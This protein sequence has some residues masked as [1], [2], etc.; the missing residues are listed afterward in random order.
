[1][2][3]ELLDEGRDADQHHGEQATEGEFGVL[4]AAYPGLAERRH[5]IG[6]R[7]D[8][9]QRGAAAG[10]GLEQQQDT[11]RLH[12]LGLLTEDVRVDRGAAAKQ[13][14]EDHGDDRADADDR[15]QDERPRAVRD[16]A[17]VDHG[18]HAEADPHGVGEQPGER[19][20]QRCHTGGDG[21]RHV[22]HVVDDQRGTGVH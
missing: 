10:E 11:H 20:G 8:T 5:G 19:G 9:G 14:D 13:A 12:G 2:H 18:E 15:G 17:Q 16:A 7:L 3:R 1:V 6:D 22:E 21:H 4:G